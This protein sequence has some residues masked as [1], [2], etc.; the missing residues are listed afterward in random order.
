MRGGILFTIHRYDGATGGDSREPFA[1]A[2][3]RHARLTA[4]AGG[5]DLSADVAGGLTA[6][7]LG[8]LAARWGRR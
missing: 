2:G 8:G 5:A 4:K 6:I 1:S 3:H 7:G